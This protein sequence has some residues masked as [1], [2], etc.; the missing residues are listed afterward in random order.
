[1]YERILM[2]VPGWLGNDTRNNSLNFDDRSTIIPGTT[3]YITRGHYIAWRDTW[4]L[5][6]I[7]DLK[8]Y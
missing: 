6:I 1:M 5:D 7:L 3:D 4:L 2:T 8:H